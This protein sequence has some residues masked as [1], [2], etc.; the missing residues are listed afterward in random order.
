MDFKSFQEKY[1]NK[2]VKEYNPIER[3]HP[4]VSVC[5]QTYQHVN[6]IR[7][8][9]EG[10]L[11]QKTSFPYEILLGEDKSTDG[12][13]EICIEYAEKYP[14]K[15]RLFLHH[16]ENNIKIGGKATGRFIF[17]YNLFLSKG[18]YIALCEGDDYWIDENKLQ[19][20][21]DF[22]KSNFDFSLTFHKVKILNS[23][24]DVFEEDNITRAVPV[25]T[26]KLDLCKGN[27]IHT[28]SVVFRNN[29]SIPAWFV[30]CHIGDWALYMLATKKG[31]IRKFSEVMAIYRIGAKGVWSN[32]S[33]KVKLKKTIETFEI[34]LRNLKHEKEAKM[35]IRQTILNY[36][37]QLNTSKN[38]LYYKFIFKFFNKN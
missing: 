24:E 23:I 16:R 11:M 33:K 25:V 29:F 1:E 18:E 37:K 8:C 4:L 9:L 3:E 30:D 19:N 20:Q 38:N 22:L 5:V 6:Y 17:L 32:Q 31:E 13:R 35:I 7:E 12:T 2:R 34:V 27:Y 28:P 21:I 26:S 10:I 14:G 36:K 15:I